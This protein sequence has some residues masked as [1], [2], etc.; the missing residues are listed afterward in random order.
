[1]STED[2]LEH[3]RQCIRAEPEY[4]DEMSDEMWEAMKMAVRNDDKEAMMECFRIAVRQTK[5]GILERLEN[6]P[7]PGPQ[8][9]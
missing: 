4:P 7:L 6:R 3:C 9:D 8:R 2:I 5:N 1:M